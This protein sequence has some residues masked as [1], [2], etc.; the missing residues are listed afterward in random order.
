M[1]ARAQVLVVGAGPAGLMT[2]LHLKRQGV[3]V[4]VVDQSEQWSARS[5]AVVLHPRTVAMLADLG[6]VEP[7]RWQGHAFKRIA[8][9]A[10]GERQALLTVPIDGELAD[11]GLTLPQNVLRTALE[12]ALRA[13]G[14]E[15]AYGYRLLSLEQSADAVHSWLETVPVSTRAHGATTAR[16]RIVSDFVIGADG[17]KSAVRE[18]LGIGLIAAEKERP[19]VFFDVPHPAPGG[20]TAELSLGEHS[21]AM[22]PLHG[23]ST[24]YS[25]ELPSMP[26]RPLSATELNELRRARMPWHAS[27]LESVEWSGV[28]AFQAAHAARLGH[29]RVWLVG[30]ACHVA[31]PIGAQSLNVGLREARDLATGVIDCLNGRN[32]ERLS[33]GYAEQR[34]LEWRR[35]LAVGDAPSFG[36]RTPAWAAK[37]YRQLVSCLPASGDDLDD[38]LAQLGISVL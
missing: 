3:E 11:G 2:A 18:T 33:V 14:V 25:F 37:H 1:E 6:V 27:T 30:D 9:F 38:L 10:S 32:L 7:L 36:A 12:G 34:R 28:R 26:D 21:S 24:R 17:F 16:S 29:A 20:T 22:Y 5:F 23:G 19:F 13:S 8:L 15:V 31:S 35:L 4:A